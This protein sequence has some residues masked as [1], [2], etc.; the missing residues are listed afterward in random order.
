MTAYEI[1]EALIP[2][3]GKKMRCSNCSE[4]FTALPGDLQSR[5][6]SAPVPETEEVVPSA[7]ADEK[8]EEI[9]ADEEAESTSADDG[10]V[11]SPA[12]AEAVSDVPPEEAEP[13]DTNSMDDIF[14]RLSVQ[15]EGL[16][17]AENELPKWQLFVLKAKKLVGFH[18]KLF[19]KLLGGAAIVLG[20]LGCYS[21]RFEIVRHVSFLRYIYSALGIQAVVPGEGLEF[22]N[23][24]WNMFEEDYVRKMAIKGFIVNPQDEDIDLPVIHV[25]MLD[26]DVQVLQVLNQ[27]PDIVKLPAGERLAVNLVVNK[28]SPLTKYVYLTFIHRSK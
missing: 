12:E 7:E 5:P 28:P 13:Q 21:Y 6:E 24:V 14:K 27:T 4:I 17:K 15:T 16:F 3:K 20:L 9:P 25:E 22:E 26:S 18:S 2:A 19:R 10:A 8:R 23:I 11:E 1:D